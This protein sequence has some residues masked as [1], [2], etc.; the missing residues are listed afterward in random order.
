MFRAK[1]IPN[2]GLG[3]VA[4]FDLEPGTLLIEEEPLLKA[5]LDSEG[6][7]KGYKKGQEF[8]V[9][10]VVNFLSE[11]SDEELEI[12]FNLADSVSLPGSKTVFGILKTNGFGIQGYL[13]LFPTIAR[14]NHSCLPNAHHYPLPGC[15]LAVRLTEKVAKNSEITIS[16]MDPLHRKSFNSSSNRRQILMSEFGF[17][18]DCQACV[19]ELNDQERRRIQE[20]DD[21]QETWK[22][23]KE[24]GLHSGHH[25][26]VA[27]QYVKLLAKEN[28]VELLEQ[29][30]DEA[31]THAK[32]AYGSD[33]KVYNA[34]SRISMDAN[35][36]EEV[37]A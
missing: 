11:R 24:I 6:D 5:E 36:I 22:L 28:N 1:Q 2:K 12:F 8:V 32:I 20:T 30:V 35:A 17:Q 33:S 25:C 10:S 19:H 3:L 31:L 9:P 37:M 27:L 34:F 21:L 23:C 26:T 7:L 15:R 29:V 16:Y 13:A 18:C 4:N 14:I